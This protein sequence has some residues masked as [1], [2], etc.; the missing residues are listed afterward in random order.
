MKKCTILTLAL[1]FLLV[2]CKKD[3]EDE[4]SV[5]A[6]SNTEEEVA[7]QLEVTINKTWKQTGFEV[8]GLE[9]WHEDN[10]DDSLHIGW[11]C[12]EGTF[13]S[14]QTEGT[15]KGWQDCNQSNSDT[16]GSFTYMHV[17]DSVTVLAESYQITFYI[18][19]LTED[20]LVWTMKRPEK[21]TISVDII[22]KST[23]EAYTDE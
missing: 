9:K 12:Q 18:S 5:D 20:K 10:P 14:F 6:T 3:E 8:L 15:Y 17:A 22:L 7:G 11:T 13:M 19:E 16:E 21:D 23:Y 2:A 4:V 1:L